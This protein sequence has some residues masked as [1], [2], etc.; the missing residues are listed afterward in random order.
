MQLPGVGMR[1]VAAAAPRHSFPLWSQRAR[2][3]LAVSPMTRA[4][5]GWLC[6]PE[7]ACWI[8]LGW[9]GLG[10]ARRFPSGSN[11]LSAVGFHADPSLYQEPGAPACCCPLSSLPPRGPWAQHSLL[12]KKLWLGWML[13]AI[14]KPSILVKITW[15]QGGGRSHAELLVGDLR[16]EPWAEDRAPGESGEQSEVT[17]LTC[18]PL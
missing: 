2:L 15:S 1:S 5:P 8:P 12:P 16:P 4:L 11:M 9:R 7:P 10:G 17:L 13:R 18:T 14:N 6:C 3:P